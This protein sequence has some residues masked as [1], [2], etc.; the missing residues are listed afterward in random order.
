ME[1]Y[2]ATGYAITVGSDQVRLR[3]ENGKDERTITA[4]SLDPLHRDSHSYLAAALHGH[5]IPKGDLSALDTNVTVM[6]ILD[7][8]REGARTGRSVKL[9]HIAIES[10]VC[11]SFATM[12]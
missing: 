11:A 10:G 12:R 1:V 9:P 6:R 4:P 7:V 5:V 2:G 8:A 3:Y